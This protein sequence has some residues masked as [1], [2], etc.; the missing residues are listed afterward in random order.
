[1][2]LDSLMLG[3]FGADYLESTMYFYFWEHSVDVIKTLGIEQAFHWVSGGTETSGGFGAFYYNYNLGG[4]SIFSF[5]TMD[6][7]EVTASVRKSSVP[8]PAPWLLMGTAFFG[9]IL[10]NRM[11]LKQ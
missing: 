3:D 4:N 9:L 5:V 7:E 10:R 11:F 2:V 6:L 8:E 1:M